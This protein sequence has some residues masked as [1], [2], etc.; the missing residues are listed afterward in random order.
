[1]PTPDYIL[2]L[3]AKIGHALVMMPGASG[4]VINDQNEILLQ[5]RRD[6]GQWGLPGGAIDPDEDPAE[7]VVRELWEEAG[8]HVVPERIIG[9]YGGGDHHATYPNGDEVQ[10]IS[11]AFACRVIDGEPHVHDEES[12]AFAYFAQD[13]LPSPLLE[14]H[15]IRIEHAFQDSCAAYFRYQGEFK[16]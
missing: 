13:N 7:A 2:N 11:I 6:T 4:I 12:L 1:V 5:Q 10:V 3:R 8:V 15:R 14:R 16:K 9:I